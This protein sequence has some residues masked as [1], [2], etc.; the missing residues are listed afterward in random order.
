MKNAHTRIGTIEFSIEKKKTTTRVRAHFDRFAKEGDQTHMV[1]IFGN[2]A[3]ISA[4]QAAVQANLPLTA[5]TPNGIHHTL[6]LGEKAATYR[7]HIQIP[8][9]S[10]PLRHLLAFSKNIL[11]NGSEGSVY[12]LDREPGLIWTTL[13]AALGLPAT[14]EWAFAGIKWLS[15]SGKLIEMEGY[16]C[17]PITVKTTREEM[18]AWIG[19]GVRTKALP[20]PEYD[21]PIFWP[22][23][24]L[25]NMLSPVVVEDDEVDI[26]ESNGDLIAAA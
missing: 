6:R 1:S 19:E 9:R 25:A 22:Q 11:Q 2:D 4:I 16:A 8:G 26:E 20:F 7:G 18:L 15:D 21:G 23:Y 12:L 14:P 5:I 10:R 13:V 3:E 17:E 24:E